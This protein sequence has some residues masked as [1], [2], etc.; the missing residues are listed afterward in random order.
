M[1]SVCIPQKDVQRAMALV[2]E[3]KRRGIHCSVHTYTALMNVAIKSNRGNVALDAYSMMLQDGLQP[4]VITFNTLVDVYGKMGSWEQA[5]GVLDIMR[6][7]VRADALRTCRARLVTLKPRN[8]SPP[9]EWV[10]HDA[11]DDLCRIA[12]LYLKGAG[13]ERVRVRPLIMRWPLCLL[14]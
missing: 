2:S 7:M 13:F 11:N 10:F 5:V 9:D 14:R 12:L 8:L 6:D 3:M 1:V 4:N